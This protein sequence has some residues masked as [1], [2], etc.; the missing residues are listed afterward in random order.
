MESYHKKNDYERNIT[1]FS[2]EK[3]YNNIRIN[4]KFIF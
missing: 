3:N 1:N 4:N 2:R